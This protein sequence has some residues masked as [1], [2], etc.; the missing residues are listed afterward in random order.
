MTTP[1]THHTPT[2]WELKDHPAWSLAKKAVESL[3]PLQDPDGS[4]SDQTRHEEAASHLRVLIEQVTTL[5]PLLPHESGYLTALT[6]DLESWAT[7]GFTT[8]D[9][10]DSLDSFHPDRTRVDG[11]PLL[12]IFPMYTQNGSTERLMEA[13]LCEVIWPD[14][15]AAVEESG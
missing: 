5:A 7:S 15:V 6:R 3:R 4:I 13:V 11:T 14:F 9:F 2:A 10:F 12:V 1:V 8:P